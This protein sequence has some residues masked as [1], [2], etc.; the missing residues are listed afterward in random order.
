MR[1]FPHHYAASAV[2]GPDGE[3][4]IESAKLPPLRS[5]PP[6]EFDGPGDRWSPE[7]LL[8]AA[9]AD[10][11]VLTFRAMA[12]FSGLSWLTV[13]CRASGTLN[14]VERVTQFASFAL[15]VVLRVPAATNVNQA[16]RLLARAEQ[17]CLISNSL[18]AHVHLEAEVEVEGEETTRVAPPETA[19][20]AGV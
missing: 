19:Y 2:G 15:H 5:A 20:A 1:E 16:R 10:C 17:G 6:A 3:I 7:T 11:F 8:T 4:R 9:V 14:R 12:K 18:K 13:R